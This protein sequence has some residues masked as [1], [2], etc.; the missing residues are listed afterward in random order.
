MKFGDFEYLVEEVERHVLDG[1]GHV[2]CDGTYLKLAIVVEYDG[3]GYQLSNGGDGYMIA[4]IHVLGLAGGKWVVAR[5][6]ARRDVEYRLIISH[7]DPAHLKAI[8]MKAYEAISSHP[9]FRPAAVSTSAGRGL[10]H[11][12]Y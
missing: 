12:T 9:D 8:A 6:L 3:D 10:A 7:I 4:D 5:T 1:R 11:A 2:V